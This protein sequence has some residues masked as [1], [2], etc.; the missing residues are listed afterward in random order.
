MVSVW[1]AGLSVIHFGSKELRLVSCYTLLSGCQLS[2]PPPSYLELLT[3]LGGLD[4][5]AI[6]HPNH[7]LSD[8]PASPAL[9]TSGGPLETIVC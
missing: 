8:H 9:L 7:M 1:N 2:W 6:G 4:E 3:S 5:P